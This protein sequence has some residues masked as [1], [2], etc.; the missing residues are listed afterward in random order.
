MGGSLAL[1]AAAILRGWPQWWR[2]HC[3]AALL[4]RKPLT[5]LSKMYQYER[6]VKSGLL[7]GTYI[8]ARSEKYVLCTRPRVTYLLCQGYLLKI[9]ADVR[10]LAPALGCWLLE[11]IGKKLVVS[12]LCLQ[13]G[14]V[15]RSPKVAADLDYKGRFELGEVGGEVYAIR[16]E[17]ATRPPLEMVDK[18]QNGGR[19]RHY[20]PE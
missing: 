11:D 10:K 16:P 4:G 17:H 15:I 7:S 18:H 8:C 19:P 1:A 2:H 6:F 9:H 5:A 14:P 13:D 20:W 3:S 12:T